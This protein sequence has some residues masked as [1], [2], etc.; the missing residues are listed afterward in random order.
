M[1]VSSYMPINSLRKTVTLV[2]LVTPR[3]RGGVTADAIGWLK[4]WGRWTPEDPGRACAHEHAH[5]EHN[6]HTVL[7]RYGALV[8][9]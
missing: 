8:R 4:M 6:T 2:K 1:G 5:N 7:P 9:R 3:C